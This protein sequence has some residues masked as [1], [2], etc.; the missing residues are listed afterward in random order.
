[1]SDIK[2]MKQL[3]DE[4]KRLQ[5]KA[6]AV[7]GHVFISAGSD[8]VKISITLFCYGDVNV[9]YPE[10]KFESVKELQEWVDHL[11]SKPR[12]ILFRRFSL[13]S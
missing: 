10:Y 3:L 12:E 11:K 9:D 13:N 8:T 5:P 7:N 6:W 1:M 2:R 4:I